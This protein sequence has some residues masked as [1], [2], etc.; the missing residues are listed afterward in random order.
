MHAPVPFVCLIPHTQTQ[1]HA[2]RLMPWHPLSKQ[3]YY[4]QCEMQPIQYG[5]SVY[6]VA[7]FT[8]LWTFLMTRNR[9][10]SDEPT[11]HQRKYQAI[12]YS[13]TRFFKWIAQNLKYQ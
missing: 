1:T 7:Q 12:N 5:S 2:T 11:M 6:G 10:R 9:N 4:K 3:L 13:N 8:F